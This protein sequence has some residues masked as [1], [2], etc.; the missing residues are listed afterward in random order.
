[1][2]PKRFAILNS[3][4]SRQQP[5]NKSACPSWSINNLFLFGGFA[6]VKKFSRRNNNDSRIHQK[7]AILDRIYGGNAQT[8]E[9]SKK[10]MVTSPSRTVSRPRLKPLPCRPL[11]LITV[12]Q[13]H[14]VNLG[15]TQ[16]TGYYSKQTKQKKSPSVGSND[17][18]TRNE[19]NCATSC[20]FR[21]QWRHSSRFIKR[22]LFRSKKEEMKEKREKVERGGCC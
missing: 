20:A 6:F 5:S 1:M 2:S 7:L 19:K 14:L 9:M 12:V 3:R 4:T 8:N 17:E 21:L 15:Y 11:P 13:V 10:K 16:I 18:R 22:V